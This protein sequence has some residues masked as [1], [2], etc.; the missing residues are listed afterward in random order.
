MG[1]KFRGTVFIE[2]IS[3]VTAKKIKHQQ[4]KHQKVSASRYPDGVFTMTASAVI[5]FRLLSTELQFHFRSAL[6]FKQ[7]TQKQHKK[8]NNKN[9]NCNR[10]G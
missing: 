2:T 7:P 4:Q 8:E 3:T 1:Y 9:K 6:I 10:I 5:L